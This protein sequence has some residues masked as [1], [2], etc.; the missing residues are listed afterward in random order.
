MRFIIRFPD[1]NEGV[2]KGPE[3]E[4]NFVGDHNVEIK[5]LYTRNNDRYGMDYGLYYRKV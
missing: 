2:V 3:R 5:R 4:E 1:A